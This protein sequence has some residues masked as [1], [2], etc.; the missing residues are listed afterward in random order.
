[1]NSIF[2]QMRKSG[3]YSL[4]YLIR[5]HND[6][7]DYRFIND[8][9]SLEYDG[10]VWTASTF[11]YTSAVPEMG[12]D[13]GGTLEI[14]L[15]DNLIIE[16]LESYTTLECE[17]VGVLLKDGTVQ[18]IQ[19]HEHKYGEGIWNERKLSFTFSADDRMSMTFAPLVFS[20]Y[21]NR[22]NA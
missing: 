13:G 17:A 19:G 6:D 16:A 11:E 7:V 10:H 18:E 8:N 3:G 21:N 20:T 14:Q 22:G 4:P 1:M 12:A 15:V 9:R 2:N 5:L